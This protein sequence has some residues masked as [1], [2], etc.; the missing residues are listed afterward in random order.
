MNTELHKLNDKHHKTHIILD[1]LDK[2]KELERVVFLMPCNI[3]ERGQVACQYCSTQGLKNYAKIAKMFNR[4]L[5]DD[6]VAEAGKV[7]H[8]ARVTTAEAYLLEGLQLHS[9]DWERGVDR[10]NETV[11]LFDR[12]KIKP[13]AHSH[14]S[15]WK[16]AQ[17]MIREEQFHKE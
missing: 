7:I 14:K 10:I 1:L 3:C 5:V 8:D 13:T 12:S 4:K 2:Y 16:C 15:I 9:S 6:V 11:A 17:A